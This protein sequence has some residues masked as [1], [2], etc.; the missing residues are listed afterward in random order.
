MTPKSAMVAA[1]VSLAACAA[2]PKAMDLFNGKDL[3]G[4]KGKWVVEDAALAWKQGAG[5]IWTEEKYGDFVLDFEYKVAK[6]TNS[7]VFIRTGNP[8]DN[9]QTGLEIQIFDSFGKQPG[10]HSCGALYDAL[11]AST[12]AEKPAGE[13]NR[14][15]IMAKGP[16][17]DI[18]LNGAKILE[19]DLDKWMEPEK[20]PDGSKNKFKK[21]LKDFPREGYIGFQDHGGAVW[22]RNIRITKL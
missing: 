18:Q 3:S 1:L 14:M 16:K 4:W 11:A 7:G 19:A 17:L 15:V 2:E 21:A 22:Y 10:K 8:R 12:N 9:V 13:W 20:N 6:G 5:D